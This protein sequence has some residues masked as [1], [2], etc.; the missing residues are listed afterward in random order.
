MRSN[1][2]PTA[3][4]SGWLP[5]ICSAT[6]HDGYRF[7]VRV[8]DAVPYLDGWHAQS[9][10]AMG[11]ENAA[12]APRPLHPC[13]GRATRPPRARLFFLHGIISHGGWYESSCARIAKAGFEVHFLDRRGTGLNAA[14]RGDV[15]ACSTWVRDVADYIEAASV[16]DRPAIL[17]GI[18]WG[19]KLALAVARR[20]PRLLNGLALICPGLFSKYGAGWL[21]RLS[22]GLM[23]G[24]RLGRQRVEI[25][26]QDARLFADDPSWQTWIAHDPLVLRHL[27]LRAAQANLALS[28][29]VADP[30]PQLTVP[31]LLMLAGRDRIIDNARTRRF[32]DSLA[33]P[34]KRLVEYPE[35]AHTLEFGPAE[36]RYVRDLVDWCGCEVSDGPAECLFQEFGDAAGET[37]EWVI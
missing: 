36:E 15:D 12:T 23:G 13:S 28:R 37:V 2:Q 31:V 26:L 35:A 14:A 10:E 4:L 29:C 25:P 5:R 30:Q 16:D 22:V 19:G 24:T 33:A 7:F 21:Q 27:T 11:V 20:H 1:E 6:A 32:F 17:A 34:G 8:W 3:Q 18:S 9:M